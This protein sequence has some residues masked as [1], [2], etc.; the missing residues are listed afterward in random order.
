MD[1]EKVLLAE[2][3]KM[4]SGRKKSDNHVD[5]KYISVVEFSLN[6]ENFGFEERYVSEVFSLREITEIPGTPPYLLGVIN[7][8]GRIVSVN[9][10]KNLFNLKERGLT[11]LNKVM[12]LKNDVM[13][14]GVVADSIT[15]NRK[16]KLKSLSPPPSTL[17]M[18]GTEFITGID[19]DGLILL[20]ATKLLSSKQLNVNKSN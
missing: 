4:I 7:L 18:I 20:D 2:R 3:A 19:P 1:K 13:E 9:N 6:T 14:F 15:G 16:L 10:L 12:I 8:K 17:D 5:E 11:E